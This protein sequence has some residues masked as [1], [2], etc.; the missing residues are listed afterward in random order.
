MN[1]P[2]TNAAPAPN[3][4]V[5]VFPRERGI[6]IL[7]V[8]PPYPVGFKQQSDGSLG[9][10]ISMVKSDLDGL[11]AYILPYLNMAVGDYIKVW[12]GTKNAPVAEFS[13]TEAHFDSDNGAK[14]IP[15]HI[16]AKAM[17]DR[18][19]E[20]RKEPFW[21]SVQ[22]ISGNPPEESEA[23]PLFYKHP[24]PG[25]P[26]T[27][28]GKPF[29][30]GLKLPVASENLVD[31]TVI[32]EGLFVTVPE[33]FN[34]SIGDLVTLA[35]GHLILEI[36]VIALG[37]IVFELTPQMLA[38]LKPTDS[39]VVRSQ[40]FD[41]VENSSGWSD[42]LIIPFKPGVVLLPAPI[43][44]QADSNNVVNHAALSGDSA[45]ILITGIF[46]TNDVV[47]LLLE[48]FTAGGDPVSHTY[49]RTLTANVRTLQFSVENYR[50]KNVIR[51]NLRASY[52]KT[53]AGKPQLSKPADV[54]ISGG[55]F[56]LNPP[57]VS[58]LENDTLPVDTA[59]ATVQC[60]D[61]WPLKAGAVVELRWQ[62]TDDAGVAALIVLQQL[63]TDPMLPIVFT[64]QG[65]YIKPN[66]SAPLTV[67]CAITNP[68]EVAVASD[69]LQLKIGDEKAIVLNPPTLVGVAP[70][71]DP[72]G[73][74]RTI[75][76][77]YSA[78]NPGDQA[79]LIEMN[80]AT[81]A[82]SFGL[83]T[84]NQNNRAHWVMDTRFLVARQ[85][86]TVECRWNLRRNG[87][88]IASSP[89]AYFEI[90]PIAPE[91]SRLPTPRI[92]GVTGVVEVKKLT[93]AN[94]LQVASWPGQ[95]QG[96][97][98][99][100]K[101]QGTHKNGAIVSHQALDGEL[102]GAEQGST[103]ALLLDWFLDLKNETDLSIFFS[104]VLGYGQQPLPFPIQTY[105]VAS[106]VEL[107]PLITAVQAPHGEVPHNTETISPTLTI[108]CRGSVN[109]QIELVV[110][111]AVQQ[112]VSTNSAG[113]ASGSVSIP[114]HDASN[115]IVARAKYGNN[116]SSPARNV[117]LR[118][119][120]QIDTTPR[121]LE[122]YRVYAGWS[123]T[124]ARW[125]GNWQQLS[126]SYG[127][128]KRTFR[129]SDP[130]VV[131]VDANGVIIGL[132]WG[133]AWIYIQDSFTTHSIHVDVINIYKLDI[134]RA[135]M[136]FNSAVNWMNRVSGS[137]PVT[138]A[139]G[140][141]RVVYG[142]DSSWPLLPGWDS[143]QC[144]ECGPG[145]ALRY[146]WVNAGTI[147]RPSNV[148]AWPWCLRRY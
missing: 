40:M 87:K 80:A 52:T 62:T 31:Q 147:C 92:S 81:G 12:I 137:I 25:E 133:T 45:E 110:N 140:A 22:R 17:E 41:V 148:Q 135:Y 64:V 5:V 86:T 79:R 34:Q 60:A 113:D 78:S 91:D 144:E 104:V 67:Q 126:P 114:N 125:P 72:L 28:G 75:R 65:K 21:Y 84:L 108:T 122:G 8:D 141:M 19:P 3:Q 23:V 15:F 13:V 95:T 26:D 106:L 138:K 136:D 29:N 33:Y 146:S 20:T 99:Y 88:R 132:K 71:I 46:K 139:L 44:L 119:P 121:L 54:T 130:A 90:A 38:T 97:A 134:Y 100:L 53:T 96:Q 101:L 14:N 6:G 9:V 107:Q 63:V 16:S 48:G 124:G 103:T 10:N 69:L 49:T 85:N 61:Y 105:K 59:M 127:V 116:L 145:M 4:Q 47:V 30:Q 98:K 7:A 131:S 68:G 82:P 120:L 74:D 129:S 56:S 37:D 42:A 118:R 50:V 55:A 18:F 94:M 11:L 70:P 73:G 76:V 143:W 51:G 39:L 32:D 57:T 35:F 66:P 117:I 102:T 2:M 93:A 115:S 24:A 43:F 58:P 128:G 112:T 77:E 109:E 123:E 83:I 111:G 89:V 142:P 1:T 27:D 36:T